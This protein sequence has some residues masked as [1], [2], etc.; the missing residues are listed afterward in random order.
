M[1]KKITQTIIAIIITGVVIYLTQRF[2]YNFSVL[3]YSFRLNAITIGE[4]LLIMVSSRI[5]AS[6]YLKRL[7]VKFNE[8]L[9]LFSI[10]A[11]FG[12]F[13]TQR[14]WFEEYPQI[15]GYGFY[16]ACLFFNMSRVIKNSDT[17]IEDIEPLAKSEEQLLAELIDATNEVSD[18]E[19]IR[20]KEMFCSQFAKCNIEVSKVKATINSDNIVYEFRCEKFIK[21]V[22]I[23]SI[24]SILNP[25][26]KFYISP[27]DEKVTVINMPYRNLVTQSQ[28]PQGDE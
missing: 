11:Y 6:L 10:I 22:Q 24:K 2:P 9:P 5:F 28:K 26:C 13:L 15:V 25:H 12:A 3:Y 23:E 19:I 1:T 4:F 7:A 17:D 8:L 20:C 21:E 27:F 18:E 14:Y 16:L